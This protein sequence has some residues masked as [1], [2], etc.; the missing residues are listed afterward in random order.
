MLLVGVVRRPHGLAGEVSVEVATD[1]PERFRPGARLRWTRGEES[2]EVVV[3]S[4]RPHGARWLLR[5][6]GADDR[7]AAAALAAGDLSV[8]D[9]EAKPEPP[10]YHYSHRVRGWRC[11]T[12]GGA[13][14]GEVEDLEQSPAGPLLTVATPG[15]R[16]VLVPFVEG[17]VREMDAAGRRVVLDPPAGLFDL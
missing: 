14:L 10:G 17:I 7:D 9:G 16:S 15:G 13:V 2:R 11:E 3:A 6:E 8:D 12:P 5:F 4:A 1:F